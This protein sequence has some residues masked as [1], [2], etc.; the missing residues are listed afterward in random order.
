MI[1]L[2]KPVLQGS[3]S[4][5]FLLI[6]IPTRWK[7]IVKIECS[8]EDRKEI[9]D[10]QLKDCYSSAMYITVSRLFKILAGINIIIPGS[11]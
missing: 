9:G 10:G 4:Y 11:F 3:T 8:E 6:E 5:F 2:D 7:E 1:G